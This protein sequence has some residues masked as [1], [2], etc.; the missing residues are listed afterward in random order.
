MCY[1]TVNK[2]CNKE[3]NM[4]VY[5]T[6]EEMIGITELAKSLNFFIKQLKNQAIDKIAIMKNNRPEAVV[7]PIE[8]YENLRADREYL[9]ELANVQLIKERMIDNGEPQMLTFDD[10]EKYFKD[11]GIL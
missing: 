5:Y 4:A 1:N 3:F 6:K 10:M 9:E 8:E 2:T 7:V 11:R